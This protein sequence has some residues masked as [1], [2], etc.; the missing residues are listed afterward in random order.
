[1]KTETAFTIAVW[2]LTIGVLINAF[3]LIRLIASSH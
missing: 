3:C 1:M 2:L